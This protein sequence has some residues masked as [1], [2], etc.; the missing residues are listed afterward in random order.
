MVHRPGIKQ[1]ILLFITALIA[2]IAECYPLLNEATALTGKHFISRLGFLS[3]ESLTILLPYWLLPRKWRCSILIPVWLMALWFIG[4]IWYYRF[5]LEL[6]DVSA[7][8]LVDNLNSELFNSTIGLWKATDL[9]IL[10]IPVAATIIYRLWLKTGA[11]SCI[12]PAKFKITAIASTLAIYAIAFVGYTVHC[13]RF[14]RSEGV[15]MKFSAATSFRLAHANL[16]PISSLKMNGIVSHFLY[17]TAYLYEVLTVNRELSDAENA[18]INEFISNSDF[19]DV[20]PDSVR[21]LNAGKN[22]ILIIVESL[23]SSVVHTDYK[24]RPIAPTVRALAES[25]SSVTALDVE[26]QVCQGGSGDG[27][28]IANTGLLPLPR[29][30]TS[31]LLGSKNTFPSLARMLHRKSSL[32]IFADANLSWNETGTFQNMGFDRHMCNTEYQQLLHALGSDA[33]MFA[34]ADSLIP[35]LKQ[36]FFLELLT[37]SMHIPFDD[38]E[39]PES[40]KPDWIGPDS[41]LPPMM[42]NYYRMVSYFDTALARFI[43]SL[44]ARG[45][46]ENT[47]LVL[48]SDHSQDV[49]HESESEPERMVFIAANTGLTQTIDRRVGQIDVY[50]TILHLAGTNDS[51]P[52]KGVGTSLLGPAPTQQCRA[53]AKEISELIL[54]GDFFR[55][56]IC[57]E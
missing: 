54:R 57:S 5:W 24:G 43:E 26:T 46:Y 10:L 11:E 39:V 33:A 13:R 19:P 51:I 42:L 7:L 14:L 27:Q 22:V 31:I 52:W 37:T 50:P 38:P 47:L 17:S 21:N 16:S 9:L 45:L 56:K 8:L 48:V 32:V 2:I 44:K 34:V 20:L 40:M 1:Y 53:S 29:F 30:S 6:P 55:G 35:T 23:N 49:L 18:R 12:L 25:A 3:V 4:S 28:L 36:P 15:D 41:S